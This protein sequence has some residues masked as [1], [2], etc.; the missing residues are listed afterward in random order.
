MDHGRCAAVKRVTPMFSSN[1]TCRK[2]EGN[3][4][5]AVEQEETLCDEVEIVSEFA[6][7]VDRMSA[8]GG[9]EVAVT[10]RTRCGWV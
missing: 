9:C 3:I 7:L 10:V 8:G 4:G 1:C 2:Y 6:Y 5:K